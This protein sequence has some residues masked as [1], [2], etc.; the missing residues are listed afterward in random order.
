MLAESSPS[1]LSAIAA[2]VHGSGSATWPVDGT[3]SSAWPYLF[4]NYVGFELP[5]GLQQ[6][7]FIYWGGTPVSVKRSPD[8]A[9]AGRAS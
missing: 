6:E 4:F 2:H 5:N 3:V 8:A 9:S 7:M 1:P